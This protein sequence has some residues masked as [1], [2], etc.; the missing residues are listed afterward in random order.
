[1]LFVLCFRIYFAESVRLEIENRNAEAKEESD[2]PVIVTS[3][4]IQQSDGTGPVSEKRS[5]YIYI[6]ILHVHVS[7]MISL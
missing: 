7:C 1:M 6:Y 2:N 5:L 3:D 4:A